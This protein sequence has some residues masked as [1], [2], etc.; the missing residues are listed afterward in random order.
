MLK[1][2]KPIPEMKKKNKKTTTFQR[3]SSISPQIEPLEE[4]RFEKLLE[5]DQSWGPMHFLKENDASGL[6]STTS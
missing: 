1:I 6:Q 5:G 3:T 2:K 4:L